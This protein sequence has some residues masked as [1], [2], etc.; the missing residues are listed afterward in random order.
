MRPSVTRDDVE[1]L[2]IHRAR[3]VVQR[4]RRVQHV[5][6][7]VQPVIDEVETYS[8]PPATH[9]RVGALRRRA[10]TET[11]SPQV[12]ESLRQTEDKL[13]ELAAGQVSESH[14]DDVA[15]A[16]E[17][18]DEVVVEE[19]VEDVVPLHRR[20]VRQPTVIEEVQP[21]HE[22]VTET[23]SVADIQYREPVART[24]WDQMGGG[25]APAGGLA[26]AEGEA[27]ARADSA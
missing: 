15:A 16:E 6:P 24:E 2:Y 14:V 21:V 3:P 1:K 23:A 11:W 9:Q 25:G 20:T 27:R 22:V 4:V 12:R 10:T 7:V 5:V 18:V 13:L 8:L 26:T 19:T 17:I